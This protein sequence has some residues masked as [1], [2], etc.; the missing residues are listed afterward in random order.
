MCSISISP[1]KIKGTTVMAIRHILAT[2]ALFILLLFS[3]VPAF[4]DS[5]PRFFGKY[6]EE[7]N[8]EV[9]VKAVV[10][11]L[12]PEG[13]GVGPVAYY[14]MWD[15]RQQ[16]WFV[17]VNHIGPF[18]GQEMP[19]KLQVW[20]MPWGEKVPTLNQEITFMQTCIVELGWL[21]V[22]GKRLLYVISFS[23]PTVIEITCFSFDENAQKID[24]VSKEDFRGSFVWFL[25]NLE[26][27]GQTFVCF[28]NVPLCDLDYD[29]ANL[30]GRNKIWFVTYT[31]EGFY[32]TH[33]IPVRYLVSHREWDDFQDDKERWKF[34]VMKLITTDDW[35]D[36]VWKKSGP[37]GT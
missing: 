2:L 8:Q 14:S 35:H 24:I 20:L 21:D 6:Y 31:G 36:N 17:G 26:P 18:S 5:C 34:L 22:D 23:Y 29:L 33:Y 10:G 28:K 32:E 1:E 16:V 4:A 11:Q 19:A 12:V 27:W 9:W 15:K 25:P 13:Y 37:R 30:Y 3:T 7:T